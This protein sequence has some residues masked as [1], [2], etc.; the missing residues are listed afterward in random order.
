M[1]AAEKSK[2]AQL[3]QCEICLR[4]VPASEMHV[5]EAE[6]YSVHFC[7]LECYERWIRR[8]GKDDDSEENLNE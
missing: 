3:I 6:E 5:S 2:D 7:G 1:A 4:E 8:A